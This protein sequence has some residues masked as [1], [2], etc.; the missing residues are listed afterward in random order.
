MTN[1]HEE[2]AM[3]L[4]KFPLYQCRS[5]VRAAKI[6]AIEDDGEL[7][8]EDLDFKYNPGPAWLNKHHPEPGGY[9]VI[10]DTGVAEFRR[11]CK[12]EREWM[13]VEAVKG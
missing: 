8:F 2:S 7:V 4:S 5:E 13:R 1:L 9:L 11:G 10:D 6:T 3:T 12:F